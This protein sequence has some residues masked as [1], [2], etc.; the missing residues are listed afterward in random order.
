MLGLAA[1]ASRFAHAAAAAASRFAHAAAAH[2][3]GHRRPAPSFTGAELADF[4][5]CLPDTKGGNL[6]TEI[7]HI[8]N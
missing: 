7:I 5:A 6:G 4:F 8:G 1:A 3:L 2:R